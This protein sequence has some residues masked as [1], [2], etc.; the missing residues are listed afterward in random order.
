VP[1]DVK[2]FDPS[3]LIRS[4]PANSEDAIFCDA[5]ARHAVH[6]GMA[7][8]TNVVIGLWNGVFTHVP[9]PLAVSAKKQV[10]PAGPLWKS[11]LAS[12]GQPAVWA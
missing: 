8:K 1:V 10:D 7:G 2:Y 5:L 9:I 12:T 4:V 3:Y 11:V 6:A